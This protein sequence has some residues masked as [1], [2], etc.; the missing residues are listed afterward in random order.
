MPY[1]VLIVDDQKDVSRLLRSALETIEQGLKVSEAP[2]GEEAILEAGR[3]KV[4][5]LIA[6]FRLPGINGVEL[7]RKFR[8][9]NPEGKVIL[10]SGVSDPRVL[11]EVAECGADAFFSK[12]VPMSDFLDAVERCLGLARTIINT[13]GVD[14]ELED[15]K[16]LGDLLINLRKDLNA[17]SVLLLNNQGQVVAEAGQLP[18]PRNTP[19]MISALL[20]M[21]NAAQK[22]ANLLD[23][24]E[25]HLHLFNGES[26]DGI[27]LPI[28]PVHA[29]LLAGEGLANPKMMATRLD[30]LFTA[31][32]ELLNALKSIGVT[33][34][35]EQASSSLPVAVD[36]PLIPAEELSPDFLDVLN[37]V[38]KKTDDVNSFW[39]SAI[40]KGTTFTEPDK[41][42]YE[43]ASRLGL[44]PDSAQDK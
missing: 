6:D 5:L 27:F 41:L 30:L 42:T 17:Q 4:D 44:A 18:E 35:A 34:E 22:I 38:G 25:N 16:G 20:G 36:E 19:A 23:R 24:T 26:A 10:I 9:R 14:S 33:V 8:A 31:R 39:D 13:T 43:Q 2:S 12:P 29:L 15:R 21:F 3:T 37:Q 11:K 7:T 28:G 40:E 1:H 32:I